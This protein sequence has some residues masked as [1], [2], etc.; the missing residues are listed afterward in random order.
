MEFSVEAIVGIIAIVIS[1][2]SVLV[3]I[4]QIVCNRH[5]NRGK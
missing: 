3:A 5:P 1:I 4:W 2:P